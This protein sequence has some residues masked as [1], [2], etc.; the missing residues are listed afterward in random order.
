MDETKQNGNRKR[1]TKKHQTNKTQ[2]NTLQTHLVRAICSNEQQCAVVCIRLWLGHNDLDDAAEMDGAL[3]VD[4]SIIFKV[5]ERV[6]QQVEHEPAFLPH[7]VEA[8]LFKAKIEK[9]I[10]FF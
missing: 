3:D 10:F 9:L 7:F 1:S 6:V 8:A 4:F 5:A 2:A